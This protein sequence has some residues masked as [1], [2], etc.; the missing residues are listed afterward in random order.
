VVEQTVEQVRCSL[1]LISSIVDTS[2]DM[3][4]L[5]EMKLERANLVERDDAGKQPGRVMT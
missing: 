5:Q 3:R 2:Q 1:E 4:A